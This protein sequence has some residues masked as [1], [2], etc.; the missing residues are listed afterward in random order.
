MSTRHQLDMLFKPL[1]LKGISIRNRIVMAPMNTNFADADGSVSDRFKKFYVEIGKGG[2]GL[3]IVSATCIDL[4]AR[5]RVGALSLY[6]DY[7]VPKLKE[8]ADAVHVTGAKVI[9]QLNHNGRL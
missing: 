3:I 4:A 7:F 6:D 2:T 5:K 1:N 9:Q 8:F